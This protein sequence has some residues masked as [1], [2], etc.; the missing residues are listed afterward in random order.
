MDINSKQ[1]NFNEIKESE[2]L[3]KEFAADLVKS[4]NFLKNE[5]NRPKIMFYHLYD[6]M[7]KI[8]K[9]IDRRGK[10]EHWWSVPVPGGG[11]GNR[12]FRAAC[13]DTGLI[14]WDEERHKSRTHY[15]AQPTGKME[16]LIKNKSYLTKN[17]D[18]GTNAPPQ[19]GSH[20]SNHNLSSAERQEI[21]SIAVQTTENDFK[22]NGYTVEDKQPDNCGWD[23]DCK[24]ESEWLRVEVKGTQASAISFELTPNE[25]EKL[26]TNIDSYR[27]SA[28]INC[29]AGPEAIKMFLFKFTS[30]GS[31]ETEIIGRCERSN[32]EIILSPAV[33]ARAKER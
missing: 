3:K 18:S 24:K 22:K 26:K 30:S 20:Y 1:N 33:A 29:L 6:H 23:L 5:E 2:L 13:V 16:E 31:S 11:D 25:F 32:K 9:Y 4:Y 19:K 8:K 17:T 10:G 27:V 12:A 21:E 15:R 7:T 14:T 28:V